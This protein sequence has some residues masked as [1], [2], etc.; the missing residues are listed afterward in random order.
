MKKNFTKAESLKFLKKYEK[1]LNIT[2]PAFFFFTKK[3]YISCKKNVLY[4][5]IKDKFKNKKIIIRS[6]SLQEDKK[7]QSSAGKYKSFSNIDFNNRK[8]IT[9]SIEEIIADFNNSKDQILIQE[10]IDNPRLSGVI[11]TR[12]IKNNSPYFTISYD[13]SG[14]TNLITS[15][16]INPTMKTVK[17]FKENLKN[18]SFFGKSLNFLFKIQEIYNQE[19]LDLE[20]CLK[21]NL[22]FIF[23]CRPLKKFRKINDLEIK[24]SLVNIEKKYK[25]LNNEI[26]SIHGKYT[27]FS[28]MCDWNPAEMIGTKP[29]P[30]AS[31]LYSELI[32]DYV[33]S[34]QRNNYGYKNVEPNRLMVNLAGS[35]FIDV[36]VDFNSFLPKNLDTNIQKKAINYYMNELKKNPYNHDKIEFEI[37]ETCY[38]FDLKKKFKKFLKNNEIKK[39]II[40]LKDLTNKI[41]EKKNNILN[42]EIKKVFKLNYKISLIRNSNLSEIQKIYFLV[43][44]CKKYG[45]LPFAGLS[46]VA[47]IYT[48]IIKSLVKKNILLHK[49]LENFYISCNTITQQMNNHLFEIKKNKIKKKKFLE[50]F[51]HLRPS[52]YSINSKNYRENFYHYFKS[53]NLYKPKRKKNFN[54]KKDQILKIKNIFKTHGL[55]T[56]VKNFFYEAKKSIQLREYSKFIFSKS[57]NEI[58]VNLIAL[59]RET[60]IPRKDLEYLSIKNLLNYYSNVNSKKLKEILI[61]EIVKNKKEEKILNLLK[62]PDFLSSSKDLYIQQEKTKVANYITENVVSGNIIEFKKIKNFSELNDKIVLLENA[63]PGYDFIFSRKLKGLITCYGGANSHMSIRCLEINLPAIIGVGSKIYDEILNSNFIEINCKQNFFRKIT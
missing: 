36:R 20:F 4:N 8:K 27:L 48:K 62:M 7:N 30:L 42:N 3:Q 22:F 5:K 14:K 40:S 52:T 54:L 33:W 26:P 21:G 58:F 16:K 31:S 55:K 18:Y 56:N 39:Y 32:T 45:T 25:K 23:Q 47:F 57:I 15:G 34:K 53:L 60:N 46:R 50:K 63:D 6:S 9:K 41:L 13:L 28:N 49:D 29:Y 2:I 17:I 1:K 12:D 10:Y 11:F 19:R 43:N 24:N 35:T 51:G 44:D 59:G 38:D 61:D 37:V